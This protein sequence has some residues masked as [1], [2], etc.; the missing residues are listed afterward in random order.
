MENARKNQK[1]LF[2]HKVCHEYIF[3]RYSGLFYTIAE[4]IYG[5]KT[6]AFYLAE[7][8]K[9]WYLRELILELS[10]LCSKLH[11]KK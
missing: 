5:R 8:K 4:I 9:H 6:K 11:L 2:F 10:F 1:Y 3:L 7:Q